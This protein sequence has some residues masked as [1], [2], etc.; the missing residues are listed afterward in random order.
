MA[1]TQTSQPHVSS[2]LAPV[3]SEDDFELEVVGRIP[4]ALAGAYYR[5]GP[6]PQ[7]DPQGPY[8]PYLGDGMIQ[9]FFLEPNKAGGRAHAGRARYRNRWV[10]TPKWHAEH[11]AGRLLFEG[12]GTP[13]DPSVADVIPVPSN[14]NI[15]HHAGKL[16]ALDEHGE[17]FELDPEGLECGAFLN[18]GG[19]R[20][21]HPKVD[22][23]TGEMVWFAYFAGPEPFSNLIDYGVTDKTGKVTR[24]DRFAAPYASLVHD[25]M[26][27]R[28]YV[29]F[30]VMPLIGDLARARKG[31]PPLAWEP[32][33]SGFLGVMKRNAPVDS[34]RWFEI[35][36]RFFLHSMNAWEDGDRIHCEV[37]EFPH[38]PV[39]PNADGSPSQP[40]EGRLTRWTI[41][42][43]GTEVQCQPLDDLNAEM[44]RFDERNAGL[45]YRH[46]WYMANIGSDHPLRHNAIAHIDLATGQREERILQPGDVAGEPLFVPRSPSA[47][48]GDGYIIA[49]VYRAATNTSELLILP[50]Q[51]IAGEPAAVL[52]VPRRVPG[53]LHGN[54]VPA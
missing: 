23:E 22:P 26:V 43:A 52:K 24:R 31:L 54:F 29:M 25:F 47:P 44:P 37:T 41:D 9:G 17:P 40:T 16:L 20:S 49:L 32:D 8:F 14:I 6:F 2:A 38:P 5:N 7:F 53:G 15:I 39:F 1:D 11:K 13:V 35:E 12:F 48:E 50:A 30:P 21:A 28:N 10:R 45:P 33:N 4:D 27:T 42:L 18:T 36:P 51:D 3:R 19:K 34:I 46:G